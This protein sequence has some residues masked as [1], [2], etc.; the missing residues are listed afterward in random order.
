MNT[1]IVVAY[2][3]ATILA[4]CAVFLLVAL[5]RSANEDISPTPRLT[6]YRP[7]LRDQYRA[8]SRERLLELQASFSRPARKGI[9]ASA[10]RWTNDKGAA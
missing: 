8:E 2:V 9:E 5:M 10:Q 3:V 6:Q 7:D 4:V 1:V